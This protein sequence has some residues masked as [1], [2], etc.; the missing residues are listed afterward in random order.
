MAQNQLP[1]LPPLTPAPL[2]ELPPL[3][4]PDKAHAAARSSEDASAAPPADTSSE[5]EA[6]SH[7][8]MTVAVQVPV[9]RPALEPRA[10]AAP[11]IE[12]APA[13]FAAV[14]SALRT[15]TRSPRRPATPP[16]LPAAALMRPAPP[17]PLP[18]PPA[19]AAAAVPRLPAAPAKKADPAPAAPQPA[20]RP[21][22][23]WA[24]PAATKRRPLPKK[25][26]AVLLV[27]AVLIGLLVATQ[28][29]ARSRNAPPPRLAVKS[30]P[31]VTTEELKT[32]REVSPDN[33][34]TADPAATTSWAARA[35]RADSLSAPA[36]S[37]AD[38]D[39]RR[40][41]RAANPDDLHATPRA[42]VLRPGS[43][44][45]RASRAMTA[46]D[47]ESLLVRPTTEPGATPRD[48]ASGH[49][50]RKTTV[51]AAAGTQLAVVLATPVQ[52]TAGSAETIVATVEGKGILRDARF[53]GVASAS[54]PG[55]RIS[56]RFRKLLLADGR[57]ISVSGEAQDQD[58]GFGLAVAWPA[59][60]QPS[61]GREVATETATETVLDAVGGGVL[62]TAARKYNDKSR[63]GT[64]SERP[65]VTL[66]AGQSFTVFL[67]ESAQ[68]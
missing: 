8:A 10:S 25:A 52:L 55:G 63:P 15:P 58:G 48:T 24:P 7:E 27:A 21:P 5:L 9:F 47:E 16:P 49:E 11:P 31:I 50:S 26:Q 68:E 28:H 54:A 30:D 36:P 51:L 4:A 61:V 59:S 13:P 3:D 45:R 39:A 41:H 6:V 19:P 65:S 2:P 62:G 14:T 57:E 64:A 29:F 46:D 43:A 17:P 32:R 12:P 60:S 38:L 56:V 23:P 22:L 42:S 34:I 53:V 33:F 67:H 20:A 35:Q 66:P 1:T 40:A 37:T 44:P 18:P